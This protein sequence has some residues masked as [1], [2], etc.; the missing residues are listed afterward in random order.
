MW[1]Q[2]KWYL[3][4]NLYV[5]VIKAGRLKIKLLRHD[6]E[7]DQSIEIIHLNN[8]NNN[9]IHLL[10]REEFMNKNSEVERTENRS[11]RRGKIKGNEYIKGEN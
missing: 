4:E 1:D 5:N 10:N 3:E 9:H 2:L 8:L 6:E 7:E 11:W